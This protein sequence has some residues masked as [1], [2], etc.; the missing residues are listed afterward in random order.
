MQFMRIN[1]FIY[2]FILVIFLQSILYVQQWQQ[3]SVAKFV[4]CRAIS[5]L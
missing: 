3:N 5:P 4:V 2:C 1:L